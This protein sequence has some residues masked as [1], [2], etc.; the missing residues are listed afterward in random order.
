MQYLRKSLVQERRRLGGQLPGWPLLHQDGVQG[1]LFHHHVEG[2]IG[3]G[4]AT[5]V[6]LVPRHAGTVAVARSHGCDADRGVVYVGNGV[7]AGTVQVPTQTA[8]PTTCSEAEKVEMFGDQKKEVR[9]VD[10]CRKRILI[11]DISLL[12]CRSLG[13]LQSDFTVF[14]NILHQSFFNCLNIVMCQCH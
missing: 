7:V 5:D 11:S 1:G 10:E 2:R 13:K 14:N 8:V 12:T 3:E 4:Q 9:R 6:H